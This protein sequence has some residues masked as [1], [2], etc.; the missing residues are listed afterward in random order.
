[1]FAI[2]VLKHALI[3]TLFVFVMMMLIDYLNVMSRGR[4][5]HMVRGG[6][7][8]QYFVASFLG[9][10]PGCLGAFLNVSFY[11]HGLLSF[12]AITAGMIATS[13]DEAF[14][15][16][17]MFPNK[18]LMLFGV[19]FLLG[20]VSGWLV[21]KV[22][23]MLKIKPCEACQLQ[24]VHI[25][26][27][28]DC[29]CLSQAEI[30]P[31]L[32]SISL[33]RLTILTVLILYTVTILVG[34]LGP[35][36]WNWQRITLIALLPLAIFIATTVPEHY[37]RVH[38]WEHITKK[39]LWRVFLW[40]FGALLVIDL[41]L[42]YWNLGAFVQAHMVWVLVTASVIAIVPESGPHLIFVAM[43]ADELIPLSL[44]HI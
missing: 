29:R 18:A 13:G 43:L 4:L 14:V 7:W 22:A 6:Q 5:S 24:Q 28:E 9:A 33:P 23:A 41:G 34:I 10:T 3:I 8:R 42:R 19:L 11:V 30:L 12:G 44:I 16:L 21:D 26:Q 15:M 20:V 31:Q 2:E 1:M 36:A 25:E 38:L 17:A 40:T 35:S 32:R 37:L 27:A 39:H